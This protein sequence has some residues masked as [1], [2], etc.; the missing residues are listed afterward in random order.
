MD[1]N[2]RLNELIAE[3]NNAYFS[4]EAKDAIDCAIAFMRENARLR[5]ALKPFAKAHDEWHGGNAQGYF[6]TAVCPADFRMAASV[7]PNDKIT[8]LRPEIFMPTDS[9]QPT[10]GTTPEPKRD[11]PSNW[12]YRL[13]RLLRLRE[14]RNIE[15]DIASL[16]AEISEYEKYTY[17]IFWTIEYV[18]ERKSLLARK[19]RR[20]EWLRKMLHA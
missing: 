1:Y 2:K 13:V 19:H 4:S 18:A 8:N 3:Q 9:I 6:A 16:M 14:L 10:T 7:L 12:V 5:E 11:E 20:S 17:R 15:E